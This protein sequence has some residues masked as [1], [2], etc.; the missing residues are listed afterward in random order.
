MKTEQEAIQVRWHGN[1]LMR[2]S[3]VFRLGS[4]HPQFSLRRYDGFEAPVRA[5][6]APGHGNRDDAI[7][8]AVGLAIDEINYWRWMNPRG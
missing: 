3:A 7:E 2:A 5:P 8:A 6:I 4:W 1:F